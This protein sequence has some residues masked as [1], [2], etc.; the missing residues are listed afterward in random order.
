[1][2]P[3]ILKVMAEGD[4]GVILD[5]AEKSADEI[6]KARELAVAEP[7]RTNPEMPVSCR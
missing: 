1:M 7:A 4:Q 5:D 6:Q 3:H 2:R